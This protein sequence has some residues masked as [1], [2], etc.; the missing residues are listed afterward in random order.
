M[1]LK[2]QENWNQVQSGL[3]L[4]V[5]E[6]SMLCTAPTCLRTEDWKFNI[7]LE[8]YWADLHVPYYLNQ[9]IIIKW[10]TINEFQMIHYPK[11]KI[12]FVR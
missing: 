8:P 4:G 3:A 6:R 9:N 1:T 7:Y 10:M 5:T 11:D 12:K 2:S